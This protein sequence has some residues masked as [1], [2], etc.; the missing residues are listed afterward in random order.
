MSIG[1]LVS[2]ALLVLLTGC[3]TLPVRTPATVAP[4]LAGLDWPA[5]RVLLQGRAG[6]GLQGR[7]GVAAGTEGFNGHL[8]WVQQGATSSLDLEGPL[9]VGGVHVRSDGTQFELTRP[10]GERL[11]SDAARA[12]LADRM[13]FEPPLSHLRYWVQGVPDPALPATETVQDA[14]LSQLIQ[15]GWN[16]TYTAYQAAD[17]LPQKLS[18]VRGDVRVRLVID[19]WHLP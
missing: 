10:S 7:V 5:R 12:E 15:D 13:G 4:A 2:L 1:A 11:D 8:R 6:F 19:A 16:I 3:S 18:L 17:G 9:G 14:R